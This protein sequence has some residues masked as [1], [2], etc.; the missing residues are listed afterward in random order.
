M[1]ELQART[2][3][4]GARLLRG[5]GMLKDKSKIS[6]IAHL[7]GVYH[8]GVHLMGMRLMGMYLTGL[9]L[10]GVYL[11]GI[12]LMGVHLMGMHLRHDHTKLGL[13]QRELRSGSGHGIW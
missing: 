9:H 2:E 4:G 5:I 6:R 7:I 13:Q 3:S 10:M 1:G 11:V 12:H 8:M